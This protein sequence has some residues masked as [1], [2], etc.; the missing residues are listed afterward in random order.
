MAAENVNLVTRMASFYASHCTFSQG[1]RKVPS[2]GWAQHS[3]GNCKFLLFNTM[4]PKYWWARAPVPPVPMALFLLQYDPNLLVLSGRSVKVNVRKYK[5]AMGWFVTKIRNRM[6]DKTLYA[7]I[8]MRQFYQKP[9]QENN[10]DEKWIELEFWLK[11]I[12]LFTTLALTQY[13]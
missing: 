3:E 10:G 6:S 5:L 13:K 2:I 7:L 1:C 11:S 8:S 9:K 12:N 4:F